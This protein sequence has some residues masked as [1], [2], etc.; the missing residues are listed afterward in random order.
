[1]NGLNRAQRLNILN[2]LNP[3]AKSAKPEDFVDNRFIK[4]LDDSGFI[5][6]Q[7]KDKPR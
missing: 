5:D 4:E 3:T 7:Y 6:N 2:A 1:L